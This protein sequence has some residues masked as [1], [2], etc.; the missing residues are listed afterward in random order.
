MRRGRLSSC[1]DYDVVK[2]NG[3]SKHAE[4]D[5]TTSAWA[6]S[7]GPATPAPREMVEWTSHGFMG[8]RRA[9]RRGGCSWRKRLLVG[10]GWCGVVGNIAVVC[11]SVLCGYGQRCAYDWRH[12]LLWLL[13]VNCITWMAALIDIWMCSNLSS[14]KKWKATDRLMN[15]LFGMWEV[16]EYLF[17]GG[18]PR[19]ES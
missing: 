14:P 4:D 9:I 13:A 7:N 18:S 16:F 12:S 3:P 15:P 1:A 2:S 8:M 6:E 17:T 10:V 11:D 5:T 19:N